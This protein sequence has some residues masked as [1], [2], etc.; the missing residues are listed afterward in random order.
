[1]RERVQALGGSCAIQ[2]APSQGAIVRVIIMI[3]AVAVTTASAPK[4]EERIEAS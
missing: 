2:S 3:T 1:M 4:Y